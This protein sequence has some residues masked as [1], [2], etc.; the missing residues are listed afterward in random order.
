MTEETHRI[1]QGHDRFPPP[2]MLA[3]GPSTT[4]DDGESLFVG[5]ALMRATALDAATVKASST[6]V[7]S[8]ALVSIIDT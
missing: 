2:S 5:R 6:L 3:D 7:P 8:F 1:V 4:L